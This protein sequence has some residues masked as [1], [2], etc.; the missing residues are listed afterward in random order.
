M[1]PLFWRGQKPESGYFNI[2]RNRWG[3]L[4]VGGFRG[5]NKSWA[6]SGSRY[7]KKTQNC[8]TPYRIRVKMK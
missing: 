4:F 2:Y 6:E 3:E 1:R 8:T 5:E 7:M